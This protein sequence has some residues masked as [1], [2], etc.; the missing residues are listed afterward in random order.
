MIYFYLYTDL[1]PTFTNKE[2]KYEQSFQNVRIVRLQI[3][4]V[5]TYLHESAVFVHTN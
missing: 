5:P 1:Y 3:N 2:N 4:M